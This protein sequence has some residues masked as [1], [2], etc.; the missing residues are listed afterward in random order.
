MRPDRRRRNG[1]RLLFRNERH[2]H[3]GLR[4]DRFRGA[5]DRLPGRGRARGLLLHRLRRLEIGQR[6]GRFRVPGLAFLHARR[7]ARRQHLD[8][9][10]R[11]NGTSRP[12]RS[13]RNRL[14]FLFHNERLFH[15][16]RGDDRFRGTVDRL[17]GR[18]R[19]RR[20]LRHRLRRLEVGQRFGRF[21]AQG[22]A[23]LHARRDWRRQH[24]G[25]FYRFD[26]TL[27]LDG[28][29]RHGVCFLSDGG[30]V[31]ARLCQDR[32]RWGVDRRQELSHVL[33]SLRCHLGRVQIGQRFR[34]FRTRRLAFLHA[35]GGRRRQHPGQLHG[36][37]RAFRL[38]R[39]GRQGHCLLFDGNSVYT[40]LGDDRFRGS[41][42]RFLG[43]GLARSLLLH[44]FRGF[45][46]GQC[47]GRLRARRLAFLHARRGRRRQHLGQFNRL[48]KT[49]RLD[50]FGRHR[51]SFLF[52]RNSVHARLGDDRFRR[53]FDR[54]PGCGLARRLPRL[55]FRSFKVGQ[56][57]G[58]FRTRRLAFLH[59]RRGRRRQRLG[60]L[61]RL[62]E[63][64]RRDRFG[65][66]GLCFLFD[67]NSVH[68]RLGD[69]RFRRGFERF[70][71]CGLARR[72][73]RLRLR[74][75]E[76][77]KL[78]RRFGPGGLAFLHEQRGRRQGHLGELA[79][80]DRTLRLDRFG[81]HRLG[82]LFDH[83]GVHARLG[84]DR[85][86][87][88]FGR[89]NLRNRQAV[90][91]LLGNQRILRLR[92][93]GD[94]F[95]NV[96]RQPLTR[97]GV[98]IQRDVHRRLAD[99]LDDLGRDEPQT[100][101]EEQQNMH[102][103]RSRDTAVQQAVAGAEAGVQQVAQQVYDQRQ[104]RDE[105]QHPPLHVVEHVEQQRPT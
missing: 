77:G 18:G 33:H 9:L 102:Q 94:F 76:V 93:L 83:K 101:E 56:R 82:L 74:G 88:V 3:A 30:D 104:R 28:F 63:T 46:A 25:E 66:H 42:D 64:F 70:L 44:R 52:D 54:F 61:N 49:F 90:R 13:R 62:D 59:A 11:C 36:L 98:D 32:P 53:G 79:E 71:G 43:R 73:L 69:D 84:D 10:N 45:K 27:R 89:R 41:I 14:R 24:L 8:Q 68:A 4:D 17:P 1:Q 23:F 26:K 16:G 51:L 87:E 65:R 6:L 105:K 22:L 86:G 75:L 80:L 91:C 5:V 72:L 55:R 81:D 48:D 39:F 12:G 92:Q 7:Y 97:Q 95:A 50:R 19:A 40:G 2:F 31:H 57:F 78:F 103:D 34:R 37:D 96:Q 60:Q 58:G 20:L 47:F 67:R 38:D 100:E 85:L 15:A 29:N 99:F 21:R 35:R